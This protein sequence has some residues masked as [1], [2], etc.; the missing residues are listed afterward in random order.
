MPVC[1]HK[2]ILYPNIIFIRGSDWW[3]MSF[4]TMKNNFSQIQAREGKT[5]WARKSTDITILTWLRLLRVTHCTHLYL[6]AVWL[7]PLCQHWKQKKRNS[8][9]PTIW[10]YEDFLLFHV[11]FLII[12]LFPIYNKATAF[13]SC[14]F[15]CDMRRLCSHL[16]Y[17]CLYVPINNRLS[18]ISLSLQKA[19][20][21]LVCLYYAPQTQQMRVKICFDK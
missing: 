10:R 18:V 4:Q 1:Q 6:S 12:Y 13:V 20:L 14:W 7:N 17:I 21:N 3:E 11:Y 5:V 2:T 8:W 19:F 16:Q 9:V 15:N